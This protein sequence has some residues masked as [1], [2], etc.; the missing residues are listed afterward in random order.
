MVIGWN[1]N[2]FL[3][4]HGNMYTRFINLTSMI[5]MGRIFISYFIFP[6]FY[7]YKNEQQMGVSTMDSSGKTGMVG[8]DDFELVRV[9]GR[10]SYAKVSS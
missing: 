9:I 1:D 7:S 4:L 10:G 8:L 6:K 3:T 5:L 2:L